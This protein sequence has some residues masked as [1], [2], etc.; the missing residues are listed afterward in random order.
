MTC[1]ARRSAK[2]R[3]QLQLAVRDGARFRPAARYIRDLSIRR[4]RWGP[5]KLSIFRRVSNSDHELQSR[6]E[7]AGSITAPCRPLP[8]TE[9]ILLSLDRGEHQFPIPVHYIQPANLTQLARNTRGPSS[10]ISG[11][12]SAP[13]CNHIH[14]IVVELVDSM[15]CA[16]TSGWLRGQL[17]ARA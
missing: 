13:A 17:Q 7:H 15:T 11:R 14:Q 2:A 3:P 9:S 8:V 16:E 1:Y 12:L 6:G 4:A 5:L 10:F